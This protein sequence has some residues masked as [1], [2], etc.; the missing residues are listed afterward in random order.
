MEN[1]FLKAVSKNDTLT[2]N[3]AISN[4]S[5]GEAI[6]DQFGSVS[7][8]MGRD[9]EAVCENQNT[10]WNE[11]AELSVKFIFYLRMITRKVKINNS[12]ITIV[13]C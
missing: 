6:I 5:T 7:S 1:L 8:Y 13:A 4:S 12:F 3:G 10:L 9:Y 11:N 2:E